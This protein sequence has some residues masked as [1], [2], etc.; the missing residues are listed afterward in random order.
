[1]GECPTMRILKPESLPVSRIPRR[2]RLSF[3]E[4]MFCTGRAPSSLSFRGS[5]PER[6][7]RPKFGRIILQ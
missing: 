3:W 2:N 5:R 1:M 6:N 4:E 7:L